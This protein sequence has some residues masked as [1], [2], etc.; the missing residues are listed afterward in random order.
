MTRFGLE[1]VRRPVP[2]VG[3]VCLRGT[4]VLLIR[5]GKPPLQGAW[6]LPGGRVEWGERLEAAAL[7]ELVEETGVEAELLG[8]VDVVD[9]LFGD[10]THYVLIDYAAR[11][12]SGEPR[13][14]D[15][16]AEA[17]FHPLT[18]LG[19]LGLWAETVRVIALTVERFG[20]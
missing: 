4:D 3:V 20:G 14:G 17:A 10:D 9:G 1:G 7:R 13:A 19:E 2:G 6:S 18:R 15:D 16:A 5:R 8:L 12:R 11:W